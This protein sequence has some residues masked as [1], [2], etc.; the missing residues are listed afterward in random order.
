MA[1]S[2]S[3]GTAG[4]SSGR[5][6]ATALV[7]GRAPAQWGGEGRGF[8]MMDSWRGQSRQR[9]KGLGEMNA[10]GNVPLWCIAVDSLHF[11][12]RYFG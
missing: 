8:G 11:V 9:F 3:G 5:W 6:D 12:Y 2:S 10:I 7:S 4:S 1:P